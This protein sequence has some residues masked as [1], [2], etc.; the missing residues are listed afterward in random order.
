LCEN[1]GMYAPKRFV[2]V[3]GHPEFDEPIMRIFLDTRHKQHIFDDPLYEDASGRAG[4][5]HDGVAMAAAFL[6]FMME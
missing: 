5:P 4:M 2:S 1:Q 6:K 3:Q